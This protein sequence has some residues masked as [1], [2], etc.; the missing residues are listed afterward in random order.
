MDTEQYGKVT[1]DY[2]NDPSDD[3]FDAYDEYGEWVTVD[4]DDVKDVY[5]S[6]V[7]PGSDTEKEMM[8]HEKRRHSSFGGHPS[9]DDFFKEFYKEVNKRA[10]G[11]NPVQ[12]DTED[13]GSV[14]IDSVDRE[15]RR[16]MGIDQEGEEVELDYGDIVRF[17]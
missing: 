8:A 12:A 4:V 2:M 14:T 10:D 6:A 13:H 17:R 1:F 7:K 11:D 16:M 3:T 15:E 9:E 5:A